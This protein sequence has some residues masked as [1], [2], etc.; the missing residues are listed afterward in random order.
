[1]LIFYGEGVLVYTI[2]NR[3]VPPTPIVKIKSIEDEVSS[4]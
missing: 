1:M 4:R 3:R 2:S